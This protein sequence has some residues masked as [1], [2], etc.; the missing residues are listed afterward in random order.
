MW[1]WL[2][3]WWKKKHHPDSGMHNTY[4]GNDGADF[5]RSYNSYDGDA[6]NGSCESTAYS[7]DSDSSSC[8]SSSSSSSD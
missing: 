3:R 7:N 4:S 6:S 5:G 1:N 8:D 2:V